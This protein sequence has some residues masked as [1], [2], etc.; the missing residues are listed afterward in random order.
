LASSNL[1]ILDTSP[2]L[3]SKLIL[4]NIISFILSLVLL[5]QKVHNVIGMKFL[6]RK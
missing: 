4:N 5:M 3:E 6:T 2:G 1:G